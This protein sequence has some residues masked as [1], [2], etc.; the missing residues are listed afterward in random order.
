M[1]RTRSI[2]SGFE[3][4]MLANLRA[5]QLANQRVVVAFSGGP[6][7]L[8][9]GSALARLGK[10]LGLEPL[11]VH[12]DHQLRPTSARDAQLCQS[13]AKALDLPF[14]LFV[15]ENGLPDRA[16]GLGIEE[17]G[18]RERYLA[19]A[20][21]ASAWNSEVIIT[22]HQANDQAES[23]L[24]HLFRGTG[25][26]GL[27]GMRMDEIRPIP[28][29]STAHETL[30]SIRLIR[31]MLQESRR[32]IEDYLQEIELT[33]LFDES[34][35]TDDFDRN[36]IRNQLLP[37]IQ[38]RWPA[39]IETL[40]R[41]SEAS[42]LDNDFL[43]ELACLTGLDAH[44]VD[45]TLRANILTTSDPAI[46]LRV[47]RNWLATLDIEDV[48]FD[49]V[50]RVYALAIS[51][52]ERKMIEAGSNRTIVLDSD[53]LMRLDQLLDQAAS[54]FPIDAGGDTQN[55]S[56]E[57]TAAV[58]DSDGDLL[59]PMNLPIEIR[60]LRPGD[61][62]FGSNRRI[63]EDLRHAGIHP[64]VRPYLLAVASSNGIL[65]IPAIYP[66]IHARF[67]Q[68]NTMRAGVRWQKQP[69]S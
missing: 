26:Q 2:R 43:T 31:P 50:A 33:P 35:D 10:P 48:D 63:A 17:Q 46:A 19:L 61:R 20:E 55:W 36:F 58:S 13:L 65:L 54:V 24:L 59:L 68:A 69:R 42:R 41:S 25:L 3:Q 38:E 64:L 7:S 14:E 16:K 52:D 44:H 66:T 21:A 60:T 40:T 15:L 9:L 32:I 8:A 12:I 30:R 11:L 28:W 45:R 27:G 29:W 5:C 18:R 67:D 51:A 47:V 49:V 4:R 53:R 62:W 23:I 37:H 22:G 39:I 1:M 34:N 6:D 57:M 56:V